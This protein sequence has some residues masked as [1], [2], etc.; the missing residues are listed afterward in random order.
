LACLPAAIAM[1]GQTPLGVEPIRTAGAAH[2]LS[3]AD[4]ERRL[5]ILLRAR[6]TY[7]DPAGSTLFVSD[8]TGGIF[9]GLAHE[10]VPP[11]HEGTLLEVRGVS[12]PG[13]F[14][15][16]VK[17]AH[18]RVLADDGKPPKPVRMIRTDLVTGVFDSWPVQVQGLI[19]S[20]VVEHKY[21]ALHLATDEGPI[22]IL[23]LK[24]AGVDYER[25][26]DAAVA[27]NGVVAPDFNDHRQMTGM[28]LFVQ[29]MRDISILLPGGDPFVAGVRPIS[30]L[31][32][33]DPSASSL[34][35]VH[36]RGRVTLDWP[37][38][39]VCLQDESGG[40]CVESL[41][42]EKIL[43]GATVDMAGY[44]VLA[45][46]IP[47]VEDPV[48]RASA[49]AVEISLVPHPASIDGVLNGEHS[50]ELVS[51]EGQVVGVNSDARNWQLTLIFANSVYTAMLP[52]EGGVAAEA[53]WR[54][55]SY[56]RVTGVCQ[57][58]TDRLSESSRDWSIHRRFQSFHVLMRTAADVKVLRA[59]SWW[60]PG[61]TL[62]VL[63]AMLL[64]AMAGFG[65]VIQ[66][67]RRVEQRTEQ[68]RASEERFRNLAHHDALTGA[69]NR[70]LFNDRAAIALSRAERQRHRVGLLLLDLDH[71]KP[72]ND[73]YGHEAGDRVLCAV[74]ERSVATVR[75]SDTVARLGGDEFA[76]L[77]S[78]LTLD[79]SSG[80]EAMRIAE[81]LLEAVC[82]PV[83]L[84]ERE[85][86]VSASVGVA[87]YPDD[88]VTLAEL[89]RHA[90]E[91]MY[92]SKQKAR[93]GL[94]RY[95]NHPPPLPESS[96]ESS[97]AAELEESRLR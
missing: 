37:G 71:F 88:G 39:L 66:L 73:T 3:V 82:Q 96:P 25:L 83:S 18:V 38:R 55:G 68:L 87:M 59:P 13:G 94:A 30:H 7:Y 79:P 19:H 62:S 6:V 9:V 61:R 2:G 78:D 97:P 46:A 34:N 33:F 8:E 48:V 41:S 50:G 72:I 51:L 31:S 28:H 80:D 60:T 54:E 1:R 22:T 14:A 90:D 56:V 70:A 52:K 95:L 75:K 57:Q 35:R 77:L 81:K 45:A 89:L 17:E 86:G 36:V 44:P 49:T 91:A 47:G 85:V 63:S 21:V 42:P 24:E 20:L 43:V 92:A 27:V 84:G 5:P 65:W 16:I 4:A 76:V 53:P 64:L 10:P 15:A 11:L 69:P 74:V 58:D 12:D 67:R 29:T 93:G 26:A 32:N 23:L 40:I